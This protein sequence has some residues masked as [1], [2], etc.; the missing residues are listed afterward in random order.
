MSPERQT[1]VSR[2]PSPVESTRL[3]FAKSEITKAMRALEQVDDA[4]FDL[5]GRVVYL[6]DALK[7]AQ[8]LAYRW[9]KNYNAM[10]AIAAAR[11]DEE[12]IEALDLAAKQWAVEW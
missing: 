2:L 6:E 5:A 12:R 7:D 10:K 3:R 11:D 1:N 8:E 4:N 9:R